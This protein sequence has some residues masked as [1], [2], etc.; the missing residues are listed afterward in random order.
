MI[1]NLREE[2]LAMRARQQRTEP[3]RFGSPDR[4]S[5]VVVPAP[6]PGD[7]PGLKLFNVYLRRERRLSEHTVI[8]Y[9]NDLRQLE[10][11]L[12][13]SGSCVD[14]GRCLERAMR[15]DLQAYIVERMADGVSPR[16]ARRKLFAFRLF[17]RLLLDEEL[18]TEVPTRG[19]PMPKIQQTLPKYL[20]ANDVDCV[21]RWMATAKDEHGRRFPL[22]DRAMMLT[23]FAS[24]L[25]ASELVNLKL[26]DLDLENGFIKVW[27]GKGGKDGIV[28][29]SPP[30]IEALT[31]YIRDV[32]PRHDRKQEC[33][34][35]FLSFYHG[36]PI[37]RQALYLRMRAIG[38]QALG[39]DVSPHQFRHA[40]AT[41]LL[42][43]GADIRDVQ[44][45]LRHSDIDTTQIYLH[46]DVT[47]LR[48]IYDKSHPRA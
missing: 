2:Q 38:H 41:A 47:Y 21:V 32:R 1:M 46:V 8:N 9:L 6:D 34:F 5:L 36:G 27:N 48:G 29:L 33:P 24:G 16:T 13:L 12:E 39:R 19:I 45:V 25:R 43:G 3:V 7:S 35:V 26:A 31:T 17:Y 18:I 37:S 10:T 22:R 20:S 30:A 23:L 42:K 15:D 40:C 4:P 11:W 44:A 28:P 14:A